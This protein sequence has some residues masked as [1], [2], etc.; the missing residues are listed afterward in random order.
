MPNKTETHDLPVHSDSLT[1]H[2]LSTLAPHMDPSWITN[3]RH[4]MLGFT[5]LQILEWIA[6]DLDGKN[7]AVVAKSLALDVEDIQG[8]Q[9]VLRETRFI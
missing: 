7:K 4:L 8:L 5:R 2:V 3:K 9:R 1:E 6:F